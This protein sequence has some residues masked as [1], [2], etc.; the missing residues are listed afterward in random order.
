MYIVFNAVD[1]IEDADDDLTGQPPDSASLEETLLLFFIGHLSISSLLEEE[2]IEAVCFTGHFSRLDVCST[3][4]L[5]SGCDLSDIFI[6]H[7]PE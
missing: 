2:E 6:G 5:S 3:V 4:T 7:L 1:V